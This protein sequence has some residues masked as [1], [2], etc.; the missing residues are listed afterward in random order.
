MT[1]APAPAERRK[2]GEASGTLVRFKP[3]GAIFADP[4]FHW[5]TLAGRLRELAFLN[6][7]LSIMLHDERATPK[8]TVEFMYKG[9]IVEFVKYLNQNKD[10][11]HAKPVQFSRDRDG[12]TSTF[13]RPPGLLLGWKLLQLLKSAAIEALIDDSTAGWAADGVWAIL[14]LNLRKARMPP[15]CRVTASRHID[16]S[17]RTLPG[18]LYVLSNMKSSRGSW[19]PSCRIRQRPSPRGT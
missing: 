5:D 6:S 9:G 10:V 2:T 7:G 14:S 11:L 19:A 17:S 16:S 3:D 4:V 13:Q 15:L 1:S 8:K 12:T 18:K